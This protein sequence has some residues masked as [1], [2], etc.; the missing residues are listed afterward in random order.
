[1]SHL[2]LCGFS[3]L[4]YFAKSKIKDV[5]PPSLGLHLIIDYF[6][7]CFKSSARGA[8]R[9]LLQVWT[10]LDFQQTQ[11]ARPKPLGQ[12]P[13]MAQHKTFLLRAPRYGVGMI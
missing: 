3:N 1:M 7:E 6:V 13:L 4:N 2:L 11:Q 5:S 9:L 12:I 10:S 8:Q